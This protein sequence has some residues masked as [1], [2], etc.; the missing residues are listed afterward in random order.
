[1]AL[2]ILAL[3]ALATSAS[4]WYLKQIAKG[5][6]D[7]VINPAWPIMMCHCICS[8]RRCTTLHWS[9]VLP[10]CQDPTP[11]DTQGPATRAHHD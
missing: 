3:T 11:T 9:F 5:R 2:L 6:V 4:I 8:S 1:M 7:L 10:S